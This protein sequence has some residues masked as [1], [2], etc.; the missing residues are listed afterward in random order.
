MGRPSLLEVEVDIGQ[1]L[2][3]A[4]RVGGACV[5]IMATLF[6]SEPPATQRVPLWAMGCLGSF[7]IWLQWAERQ[8]C[9][10]CN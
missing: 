10:A 4:V 2:V 7:I 5:S 8:I 9:N 1:G 3:R 6:A